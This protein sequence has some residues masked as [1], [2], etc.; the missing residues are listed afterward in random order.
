MKHLKMAV[1]GPQS[2]GKT[3]LQEALKNYWLDKGNPYD[4]EFL[5]GVTRMLHE[6]GFKINEQGN[7]DTQMLVLSHHLQN[8]LYNKRF[9]ADRSIIDPALYTQDMVAQ[10]AVPAWVGFYAKELSENYA[11][12]YDLLIYV[13]SEFTPVF[14][15]VRSTAEDYHKRMVALYEARY[16]ELSKKKDVNILRVTGSVEERVQQTVKAVDRL[17]ATS[18]LD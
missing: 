15:G 17:V 16:E 7:L 1:I 2:S 10:N 12:K 4:L 13:P 5:P 9:L 6:K 14:D 18:F 11:P 3:T 8:L